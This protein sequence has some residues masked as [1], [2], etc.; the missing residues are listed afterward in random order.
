MD[1]DTLLKGYEHV[2]TAHTD[3]LGSDYKLQ[4]GDKRLIITT[5]A[6]RR[7]VTVEALNPKEGYCTL[8]SA[9]STGDLLEFL[10]WLGAG[11][12]LN[13]D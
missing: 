1:L 13:S 8:C 3:G 2:C 4:S 6:G 11:F 7:Y 12:G 9:A 10:R 5:R